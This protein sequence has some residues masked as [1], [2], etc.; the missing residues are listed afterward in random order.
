M[1]SDTI[2]ERI[3]A[4]V[5][6]TTADD[7]MEA[8]GPIIDEW[9]SHLWHTSQHNRIP[10]ALMGR[11]QRQAQAMREAAGLEPFG[12]NTAFPDARFGECT[13]HLDDCAGQETH[14]PPVP[15]RAEA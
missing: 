10:I 8:L 7:V 6:P 3:A 9:S 14:D 11:L 2:R 4:A 15:G 1:A 12:W 13:V 5:G